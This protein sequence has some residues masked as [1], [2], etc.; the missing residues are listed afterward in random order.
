MGKAKH[1]KGVF[2]VCWRVFAGMFS[3]LSS[4]K[5]HAPWEG[6]CRRVD[7]L[8]LSR[9]H[10]KS[11]FV[12]PS[13]SFLEIDLASIRRRHLR[14]DVDSIRSRSDHSVIEAPLAMSSSVNP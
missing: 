13:S 10:S 3:L 9:A 2:G 7:N 11:S 8:T 4:S 12:S 5:R 14:C 1:V 6:K